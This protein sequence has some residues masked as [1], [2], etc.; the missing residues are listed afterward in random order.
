MKIAVVGAGYAGLALSWNLLQFPEVQVSLFDGRGVAGGASGVSTGLLHPYVAKRARPAHR[1]EEA[2]AAATSLINIAEQ[3]LGRT[4][5]LRSGVFRFAMTPEQMEEF[6]QRPEYWNEERVK[7]K[8]PQ[9]SS[10]PG[11]WIPG[12]MT[13]FSRLY[14]QGLFRAAEKKGAEF[15]REEIVSLDQLKDYDLVVLASGHE[16]LRFPECKDLPLK[17]RKGQALI[18][19]IPASCGPLPCSIIGA[20]YLTLMEDPTLCQIGSTYENEF[21][22]DRAMALREKISAFFPPARDFEVLQISS[23]VRIAQKLETVPLVQQIDERCWVFTGLGSRGLLYHALF[24]KELAER[25]ILGQG[26]EERSNPSLG[27]SV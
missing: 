23:G 25:L 12:G 10:V 6:P 5:A 11:L 19:R 7:E 15:H 26:C 22:R 24:G 20:G 21:D 2:M 14:L 17:T 18:C 8:F 13:V 4:V 1:F 3:T 27:L 16:I 9:A